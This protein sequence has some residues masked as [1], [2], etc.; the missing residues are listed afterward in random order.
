MKKIM[1][2]VAIT[3]A[4]HI[5]AMD[6]DTNDIKDIAKRAKEVYNKKCPWTYIGVAK[7]KRDLC[8]LLRTTEKRILQCKKSYNKIVQ[9]CKKLHSTQ[10]V[11]MQS[12]CV[13]LRS[14]PLILA[15]TLVAHPEIIGHKIDE[16]DKQNE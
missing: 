1:L 6:F 13:Q 5:H 11:N 9:D 7:E 15:I 2:L 4:A 3:A 14:L 12:I 10:D 16:I 8:E